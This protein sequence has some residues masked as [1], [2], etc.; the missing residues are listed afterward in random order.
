[1]MEER[2]FPV[3]SWKEMGQSVEVAYTPSGGYGLA[4]SIC[5]P[6]ES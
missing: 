4:M 2:G 1:M 5:D 3:S 6:S